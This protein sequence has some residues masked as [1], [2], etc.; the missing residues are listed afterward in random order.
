MKPEYD[1]LFRDRTS[2]SKTELYLCK[3]RVFDE[4]WHKESYPSINACRLV[5]C[6]LA[7][8]CMAKFIWQCKYSQSGF[9]ASQMH[10]RHNLAV[11]DEEGHQNFSTSNHISSKIYSNDDVNCV[12]LQ[13]RHISN[14]IP[15]L[16]IFCA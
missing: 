14:T 5:M 8:K 2:P 12:L 9:E 1:F 13:R 15:R 16:T 6:I 10:L 3:Y 11:L 7:L 4:K